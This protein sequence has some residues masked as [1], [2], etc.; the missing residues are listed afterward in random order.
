[1]ERS[2]PPPVP[3]ML[4]CFIPDTLERVT[5]L[6]L[7][8]FIRLFFLAVFVSF[9]LSISAFAG[10]IP[11]GSPHVINV[12]TAA[13]PTIQSGVDAASDGDTVL[14]AD[15]TYSG[16]GNRDIDFHGKSL[17]V[18]SQNGPTKTIIIVD[19]FVKTVDQPFL[20]CDAFLFL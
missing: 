16:P 11:V 18:T 9:F 4:L 20:R 10:I 12:P 2:A 19:P 7:C 5:T 8:A 14:V 15:G 17:T 3:G 6:N 1:M 13:Y